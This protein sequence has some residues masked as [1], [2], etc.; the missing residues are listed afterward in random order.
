MPD[1]LTI[2]SFKGGT[3]KTTLALNL[4]HYYSKILGKK[5]ALADNDPQGSLTEVAESRKDILFIYRENIEA[6]KDLLN[7]SK[8]ELDLIIIDTPPSLIND[9]E[10]IYDISNFILIPFNAGTLDLRSMN[11]TIELFYNVQTRNPNLKGAVILTRGIH[12]TTLNQDVLNATKNYGLPILETQLMSR[13]DYVKSLE[14]EKGIFSTG[15]G[16][17]KREIKKIGTEILRI[18]KT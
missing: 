17:A 12:G 13:V 4:Y 6:W 8:K 7:I 5:V 15:N 3:S 11:N 16:K 1:I 14:E 9:L 2:N 10:E 18:W